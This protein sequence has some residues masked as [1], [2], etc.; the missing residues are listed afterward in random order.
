MNCMS[1]AI[2]AGGSSTRM[3]VNKAMMSFL[4]EPLIAR[5]ARLVTPITRDVFIISNE[6][7]EYQEFGLRVV[8]DVVA[9]MGAIGGL[10]TAVVQAECEFVGVVAC[11]MPFVNPAILTAGFEL[12]VANH[13]DVAI[14]K[15]AEGYEPLHAVYRKEP[16]ALA[17]KSAMDAGKRRLVAWLNEVNVIEIGVD[18]I[19]QYDPNRLSFI[20]T[21]TIDEFLQA[22]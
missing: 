14:P 5:V 12:L 21:N 16:C 3:G 7:Q 22:V 10:Y 6:P 1:V 4:G 11:D 19:E 20:N 2:Q 15:T 17:I 18:L 8:S 9:N 13:A